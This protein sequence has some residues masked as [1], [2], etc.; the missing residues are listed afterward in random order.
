MWGCMQGESKK[1]MYT[2]P[3][4]CGLIAR[5][6]GYV[7][8]YPGKRQPVKRPPGQKKPPDKRP[9]L[10]INMKISHFIT[11]RLA[12]HRLHSWLQ[13]CS[14]FVDLWAVC[15]PRFCWL[16]CCDAFLLYADFKAARIWSLLSLTTGRWYSSERRSG[17]GGT[18]PAAEKASSARYAWA[19]GTSQESVHCSIG[20]RS[21]RCP[22]WIRPCHSSCLTERYYFWTIMSAYYCRC[23]YRLLQY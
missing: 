4:C 10:W 9:L 22:A 11:C 2:P 20:V 18:W 19:T 6:N 14:K 1:Q 8:G 15:N 16:T 17:S 5:D 3:T 13:S 21:L 12:L 7:T 23:D